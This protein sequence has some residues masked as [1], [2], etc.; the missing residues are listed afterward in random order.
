MADVKDVAVIDSKG[1]LFFDV[2]KFEQAQR[3]ARVFSASDLV[4]AAFRGERGVANCVI[5][6]NLAARLGVDEFGLMQS[7]YIV[8]G[9]PG[10]EAKLAIALI[11]GGGRFEPL[12]YDIEGPDAAK[13]PYRVRAFAKEKR[14]GKILYGPWVSWDMVKAEGWDKDKPYRDGSGTQ[15]SKWNTMP[16]LMFRYRAASFF[17]RVN[18]PGTLLGVYMREEL[19]D[20]IDVEAVDVSSDVKS[21]TEQKV[22]EL[23]EKLSAAQ[24]EPAPVKPEEPGMGSNLPPAPAPEPTADDILRQFMNIKT[25]KSLEEYLESKKADIPTWPTLV[26]SQA[27]L[28]WKR[29]EQAGK[30]NKP[31]PYAQ[32]PAVEPE[33]IP[34]EQAPEPPPENA[35]SSPGDEPPPWEGTTEDK[36]AAPKPGPAKASQ[37]AKDPLDAFWEMVD[38]KL[39]TVETDLPINELTLNKFLQHTA[40]TQGMDGSAEVISSVMKYNRFPNMWKA[41]ETWLKENT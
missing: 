6:F 24:K 32:G 16:E 9:R 25:A 35:K 40:K 31:W 10:I 37:G 23:R 29:F 30:V 11:N 22:T 33:I 21:K 4:P 2:A 8:Q 5:A 39:Q 38:A 7:L 19:E 14:S 26:Y 17:V 36:P 1:G 15:K 34:A 20:V 13:P 12:E 41:Y 28:K 27:K 18:D 3:V